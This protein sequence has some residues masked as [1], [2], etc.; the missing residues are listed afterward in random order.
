MGCLQHGYAQLWLLVVSAPFLCLAS[1]VVAGSVSALFML[2]ISS[3]MISSPFR[4]HS[5]LI[6]LHPLLTRLLDNFLLPDDWCFTGCEVKVAISS[7]L[8][9]VDSTE[10]IDNTSGSHSQ[11]P[12]HKLPPSSALAAHLGL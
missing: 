4:W 11:A 3:P 6:V 5:V 7:F 10:R 8:Q 1:A 9:M 2:G 12:T